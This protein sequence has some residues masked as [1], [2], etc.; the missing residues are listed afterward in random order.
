[1][2]GFYELSPLLQGFLAGGF[3]YFS[4]ALGASLVFFFSS[5]NKKALDLMLGFSAGVMIAASFWS[6]LEPA[7]ELSG[8]LFGNGWRMP[9]AGFILGGLFVTLSDI[10]LTRA[11]RSKSTSFRRCFLLTGA[12]TLH[13]IPEGLA[14]GVA[15]G[16]VAAGVDGATVAGACML[17][18]GIAVQDFPEGACVALPLRREG[19]SR[20]KSF[21]IGQASGAVEPIAAALGVLFVMAARNALPFV[22]AF[23]AGAMV[24]I[25]C[26]ELIPEAYKKNKT[27]AALGVLLGFSLMMALDV[28]LG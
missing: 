7:V 19:Y 8:S 11:A 16:S 25:S 24:A 14:I 21:F 9:V 18:F 26:S 23:S 27:I 13:N 20:R 4:T 28:A 10:I 3:A 15:F 17:A 2:S 12:V 5:M 22:L 1:M 6:L